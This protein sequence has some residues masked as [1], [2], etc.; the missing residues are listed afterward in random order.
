[1][2]T[3]KSLGSVRF[4]PK[5]R[6]WIARLP[7]AKALTWVFLPLLALIV[8]G[9][10]FVWADSRRDKTEQLA[11]RVLAVRQTAQDLLSAQLR[12]E[13]SVWDLRVNGN[14]GGRLNY[15]RYRGIHRDALYHLRRLT[16]DDPDSAAEVEALE[17]RLEAAARVLEFRLAETPKTGAH[18]HDGFEA[19][20]RTLEAAHRAI[21]EIGGPLLTRLASAR[22]DAIDARRIADVALPLGAV[23]IALVLLLS[24]RS[25]VASEERYRTLYTDRLRAEAERDTLEAQFRQAQKLEAVGQL[26]GGIAHDFNNLLTVMLG[27]TEV[28][29]MRRD[30]PSPVTQSVREIRQASESAVVLVRQ[31]LTLSRRDVVSPRVID[32][33]HALADMHNLLRR[34]ICEDIDLRTVPGA[35]PATIKVDPG[36]IEQVVINLA[37]NAR[38]AMPHGGCLTIETANVTLDDHYAQRHIGVMPGE[39]VQLSISDNG[40]GMSEEIKARIFEPFYTTKPAGKGTG[41]GLATVYGIVK[42]NL[43]SVWVYSE[44]GRGT[45][46]KIYLPYAADHD[47]VESA[48][49]PAAVAGG[50]ETLLVVEDEDGVRRL[51][52]QILSAGGYRVVTASNAAEALKLA[53]QASC[54]FDLLLTDVVMPD[55]SGRELANRMHA[56]CPRL[57]VVYMSGYTDDAIIHHGVLHED[58]PFVEKPFTPTSLL[59]VVRRVLDDA[60]PEGSRQ[61]VGA[62]MT[63][64]AAGAALAEFDS[65]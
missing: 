35:A 20:R 48:A 43:G 64:A 52:E 32:L 36:H 39:Y 30:L 11:T 28:L 10:A 60:V 12:M 38:D 46:F 4:M 42:Q 56:L 13:G 21:M 53:G 51:T 47:R 27:Y 54:G 49:A 23:G 61:P 22:S 18:V 57:R 50:T 9:V 25:V 31:L 16:A 58:V 34:V 7:G 24:F 40:C 26:A 41:L 5:V 1:V 63:A 3:I 45:A 19:D 29:L 33:N 14:P 59:A 44:V 2:L 62:M 55:T 17:L 37:V 8:A 15:V 6:P 65:H